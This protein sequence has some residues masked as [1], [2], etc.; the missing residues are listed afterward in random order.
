MAR[1]AFFLGYLLSAL[2]PAA[3]YLGRTGGGPGAYPGSVALGVVAFIMACNQFILASRPAPALRVLG[4]KGLLAMH[5][6]LAA[7]MLAAALAHRFLKAAAGFELA[8]TQPA[9]GL[10]A[11][12]VFTLA[13]VMALLFL[14]NGSLP[15]M[16]RLRALRSWAEKKLGL[17]Y[18]SARATHNLTVAAGLVLMAHVLLASS[19]DFRSNPV[20][21]AWLVAWMLISQ[22][23]YL[24]Y[25]LR[26]RKTPAARAPAA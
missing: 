16:D 1:L 2:A 14:A 11:W 6:V 24:R 13:A 8:G 15:F 26:G 20:G 3:L 25:R 18:K 7:L 17:G 9:L 4:L 22:G 12:L 19:S 23:L 10:A 21:S 5:G